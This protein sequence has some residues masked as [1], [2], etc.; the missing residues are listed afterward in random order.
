MIVV[1]FHPH[2]M[3]LFLDM[4]I[5]LFYN[6]EVSGYSIDNKSLNELAERVYGCEDSFI[7]VKHIEKWLLSQITSGPSA[8]IYQAKRISAAI[9]QI[10]LNPQITVNELSSIVCLSKKQVERLFN[11]FVGINPKEYARIVRF[12]K[13]LAQM[14][15]QSSE[16]LNQSQI[17]YASG[18]ADQSHFIREF[19]K[20]SG[21]TPK[22]LLKVSDPY[23]DL[24]TDPLI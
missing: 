1:V 7:S 19:K 3:S 21:H 24:F 13:A 22:S 5:S 6:L 10:Y 9:R 17:A 23:S 2:A 20:F 11:S 16:D 18:Y 8:A 15:Y 12:Q 14:Q 4:P